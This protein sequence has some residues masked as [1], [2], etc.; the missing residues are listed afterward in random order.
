M[1]AEQKDDVLKALGGLARSEHAA[2][3]RLPSTSNG[4][5]SDGLPEN[6]KSA[7]IVTA[8]RSRENVYAAALRGLDLKP[9]ATLQKQA[10][11]KWWKWALPSLA[12]PAFAMAAMLL[13]AG[14]RDAHL[15]LYSMEARGTAALRGD[16]TNQH[17]VIRPNTTV[18]VVLRPASNATPHVEVQLY[19]HKD[20]TLLR[21]NANLE[22]SDSGSV[23]A[24][25]SGDVPWL[26]EETHGELVAFVGPRGA[27]KSAG[28]SD[29]TAPPTNVQV[30]RQAVVWQP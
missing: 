20:S 30:L 2:G 7:L 24:R 14:G 26:N 11:F 29:I 9:Q 23:L 12:I 5:L 25:G 28:I 13:W 16:T 4:D 8:R 19:W 17:F 21:W 6:V 22:I 1:N 15:P 27:V 18:Q 3:T 10:T